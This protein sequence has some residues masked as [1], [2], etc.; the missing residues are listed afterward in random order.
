MVAN[1]SILIGLISFF[2]SEIIDI[3]TILNYQIVR[4]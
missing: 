3:I 1:L 2:K 4:S